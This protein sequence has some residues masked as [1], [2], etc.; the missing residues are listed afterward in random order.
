MVVL[1]RG[2]SSF[3]SRGRSPGR[4]TEWF[5]SVNITAFTGLAAASFIFDQQFSAAELAKRPLTVTR[6]IGQIYVQSD[7]V[8][9][10]E[11]PFG[12][13]GMMVVSEK[14]AA[15]GVTALPDPITEEPSDEWF[16]YR[17]FSVDGGPITGRVVREFSFDS[18][19]QRKVVDG[20]TVVVMIANGSAANALRF[21]MKFRMLVKL[22]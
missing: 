12:A 18:R 10:E 8:A 1:R 17:S 21:L 5:G 15:T 16:V 3:V 20:E 7:Q 9:A 14:A 2:R 13:V 19:A 11:Q 4:L 6:T 22:S